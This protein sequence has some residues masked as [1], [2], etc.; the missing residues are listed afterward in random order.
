MGDSKGKI[1]NSEK[2]LIGVFVIAV[3]LELLADSTLANIPLV[4]DMANLLGD[5]VLNSVEL[6]IGVRLAMGN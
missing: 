4:G 6:L 2:Y 1:D 3:I 5:G